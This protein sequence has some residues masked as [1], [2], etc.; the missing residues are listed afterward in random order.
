MAEGIDLS[1]LDKDSLEKFRTDS[2]EGVAAFLARLATLTSTAPS[3]DAVTPVPL[4]ARALTDPDGPWAPNP[5]RLGRL[6]TNDAKEETP[7]DGTRLVKFMTDS[8]A[9]LGTI[10]TKQRTLFTEIDDELI[11]TI[12][13]L[14][15]AQDESLDGINGQDFLAD[16]KDVNGVFTPEKKPPSAPPTT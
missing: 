4:L 5:P 15:D 6:R 7:V 14:G 1:H 3:T 10:L 9:S 8:A 13:E 12:K 11:H 16:W 2:L